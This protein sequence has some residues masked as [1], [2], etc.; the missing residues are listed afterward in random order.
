MAKRTGAITRETKETRITVTWTLDGA[1]KAET[2]T[3]LP[4]LE[5]ML[6]SL[7]RHGGFDLAVNARGDLKVDAHHTVE[8]LGLTLGKALRDALRDKHG[9][10]RFGNAVIPMDEAL[11]R[12]AVDISG[13]PHLSYRAPLPDSMAGGINARLFREFFQGLVNNAGITVH[14]DLLAGDEVHHSLEAIFKAFARALAQAV[15]INPDT[16]EIPSTK[17]ALD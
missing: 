10:T 14:I 12:V 6:D 5:H 17:G 16:N 9:I 13:R 2:E 3:G 11:A 4:F 8:D 1:G 7:A 15:R